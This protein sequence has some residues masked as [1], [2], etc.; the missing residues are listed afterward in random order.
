M[1][2]K[3]P[4]YKRSINGYKHGEVPTKCDRH[5]K[6]INTSDYIKIK[7]SLWWNALSI[8]KGHIGKCLPCVWK[9]KI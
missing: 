8:I 1:K 6:K 4:V 9:T 2:V 3:S 5:K 7:I